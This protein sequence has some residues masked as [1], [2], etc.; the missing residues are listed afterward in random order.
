MLL[1]RAL[2]ERRQLL[3][4]RAARGHRERRRHPHVVQAS[5]VVIEPEQKR[6]DELA[7]SGLVPAEPGDDAVGGSR[8]LDLQ[9][10][11]LAG[12]IGASRGLGHHAVEAGAL[13]P[14]QP[15]DGEGPIARHRREM[16][17]FTNVPDEPLE[18]RPPF[19]L[20][21]LAQVLAAGRQQV[22]R[23]EGRGT[24]AGQ[25]GDTRRR[26][27]QPHLQRVEIETCGRGDDDLPV[28]DAAVGQLG[29]EHVVQLGKVAIERAQITAL[30]ED[31]TAA[32]EHD[33]AK[34]V[35]L[36]LEQERSAIS[37]NVF[38]EPGQHRFDRRCDWKCFRRH[39]FTYATSSVQGRGSG[40]NG[41]CSH[42]SR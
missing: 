26:R 23:D 14:L 30:D 33:G 8:V 2:T 5:L 10:G 20:R 11:A 28:H 24:L 15:L 1:E 27:V 16:D 13:E 12:L 6:A 17:R 38:R 34:P 22:E 40:R 21:P 4:Q 37:G 9:H 25:P 3:H 41:P 42:V 32:A 35:P 19:L 39:G 31:V 7:G 18:P 36:R 29:Q